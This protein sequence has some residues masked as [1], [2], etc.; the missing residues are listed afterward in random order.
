MI[1]SLGSA[2]WLPTTSRFPDRCGKFSIQHSSGIKF[3]FSSIVQ[4]DRCL[5]WSAGSVENAINF[6]VVDPC[7]F[8]VRKMTKLYVLRR[9][10]AVGDLA[11]RDWVGGDGK[12]RIWVAL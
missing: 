10:T 7:N 11:D 9:A 6:F 12:R 8:T 4:R 2:V 5:N 1:S 3:S